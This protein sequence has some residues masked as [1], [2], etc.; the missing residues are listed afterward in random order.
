M[1]YFY[2]II[3][4]AIQG[5]TEFLPVSSSGHLVVLHDILKFQIID[6]VAFDVSLHLGTLTALIF[7]FRVEILRYLAAI[8]ETFIPKREVNQADRRDVLLLIYASIPAGIAGFIFDK[9]IS[10]NAR[11]VSVVIISLLVVAALFFVVEKFT[12]HA[13]DFTGMNLGKALFIG[14]SQMLA[15]IP[16]VS[17]SGITIIAGMSLK[18]K[19]AEAARFS[20]LLSM[21]IIFGAGIFKFLDINWQALAFPELSL[22]VIG[23]FFSGIV[24]YLAVK[25]CLKFFE[26]HTLIPFAYYRIGLA[27]VLI[28]WLISGKL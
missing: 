17:R 23:F 4:G 12:K 1:L 9:F 19:R 15:L 26:R 24:G 18:L 8:I 10:T 11:R 20:F 27:A 28:I 25:Y 13:R 22:F 14:F 6:S 3:F 16:G 5:L 21:P 7:Y 2:S